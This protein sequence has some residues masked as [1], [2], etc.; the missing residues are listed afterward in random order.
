MKRVLSSCSVLCGIIALAALVFG[1]RGLFDSSHFF[2]DL[3]LFN[4]I[5]KGRFMGF[6]GNVLSVVILCGGFGAMAYYGF[7]GGLNAKK[8]AF[9]YG[10]AMTVICGIS[11]LFAIFGHIFTIGDLLIVALPA[12]YTYAVLRTA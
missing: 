1:I 10:I 8:K 3:A 7:S 9:G 2:I 12:V 4:M 11:L 5:A 6:I